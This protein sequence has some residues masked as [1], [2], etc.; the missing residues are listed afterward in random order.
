MTLQKPK[1][2]PVPYLI[3]QSVAL[4]VA[5]VAYLNPNI[6][7]VSAA[8]FCSFSAVIYMACGEIWAMRKANWLIGRST[9]IFGILFWFS[10][11]SLWLTFSADPF[12]NHATFYPGFD[13]FVPLDVI[14]TSVFAVMLFVIGCMIGWRVFVAPRNWIRAIADR[15][16]PRRDNALE[17][18]ALA[19]ALAAWMPVLYAYQ[20]DLPAFFQ[21]ILQ[22]RA[23]QEE[24]RLDVVGP[25]QHTYLLGV[26]AG[27]LATV[28]VVYG[29]SFNRLIYL[30]I[31]VLIFPL[32]FFGAGSRFNL[33]YL[34]LPSVLIL[35][36]P[37]LHSTD[38][39]RRKLTAVCL[40][41]I[42][43]LVFGLQATVR[44]DGITTDTSARFSE[45]VLAG[46]EGSDHFGALLIAVDFS[47]RR[48]QYFMEPMLP[49]FLTHLIPA[50]VWPGKPYPE[51]WI[52][53]NGVV[54]QGHGFNVTPS[55]IGQYFMNWGFVG[56]IYIGLFFGAMGR[57]CDDW[58][59]RLDMSKQFASATLAGVFLTFIF[60]SFRY[61]SPIYFVYP[62]FGYFCYRFIT[63]RRQIWK[64]EY[65]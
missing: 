7:T 25:M 1:K 24:S 9:L 20:W 55:V 33:A 49:F 40:G 22:M 8:V 59:A 19:L 41:G 37:V 17:Y 23:V 45:L 10:I 50:S 5:A 60:L 36:A 12:R 26:F 56:V 38:R 57:F 11:G 63:R 16:D 47:N 48:G 32:V 13:K 4:I 64:T 2:W 14:A 61:F 54:T 21:H 18:F 3:A 65:L 35:A 29:L 39:R 44:N 15:E 58:F 30:V 43:I 52:E 53:Y 51:T 31:I 28:R 42:F 62:L 34:V 46:S 27:S 6:G